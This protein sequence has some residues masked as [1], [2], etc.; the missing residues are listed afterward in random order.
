MKIY[1]CAS[2]RNELRTRKVV[3]A[4]VKQCADKK[5]M[6]RF[7]FFGIPEALNYVCQNF[8]LHYMVDSKLKPNSKR[9][10]CKFRRNKKGNVKTLFS[11]NSFPSKSQSQS[12]CEIFY[13]FE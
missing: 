7:G 11:K 13:V 9:I 4:I 6:K 10:Q 2:K 12:K 3:N 1:F 5:L 8:N